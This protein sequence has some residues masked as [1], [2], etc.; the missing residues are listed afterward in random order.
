MYNFT[1]RVRRIFKVRRTYFY[2]GHATS[3]TSSTYIAAVSSSP[4]FFTP[5]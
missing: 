2:G 5:M 4:S 3:D 1:G